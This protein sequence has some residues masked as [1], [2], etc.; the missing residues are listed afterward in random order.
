MGGAGGGAPP[1][2]SPVSLLLSGVLCKDSRG[3]RSLPSH[4]GLRESEQSYRFPAGRGRVKALVLLTV[5][6]CGLG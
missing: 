1:E 5:V 3:R 4:T 6:F 2:R